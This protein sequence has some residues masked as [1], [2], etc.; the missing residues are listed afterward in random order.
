LIAYE[1]ANI[2]LE[3]FSPQELYLI[4]S[5]VWYPGWRVWVNGGARKLEEGTFRFLRLS[6]G[7]QTVK[8][9]FFPRILVYG[10]ITTALSLVLGG[11]LVLK[12][13]N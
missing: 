6:P 3:I 7:Q 10:G 13:G 8:F 1:P 5:E 12:K 9:S 2:E 4:S 11:Y